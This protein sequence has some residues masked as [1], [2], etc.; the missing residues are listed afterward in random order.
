MDAVIEIGAVDDDLQ[1]MQGRVVLLK[2]ESEVR[3]ITLAGSV[4]E[5]LAAELRP[6]IVL[7]D[8]ALNNGT[9]P[10]DNVAALIRAGHK[11]IVNTVLPKDKLWIIE[12]TEAGASAYV[13][14]NSDMAALID[15]IR[16]VHNGETPTSP[17][18]ASALWGDDRP[19]APH[20]SPRQ[21]AIL[22]MVADGMPH[23][24]IARRLGIAA[25]TV[26]AHMDTVR[27]R[28]NKADLPITKTNYRDRVRERDLNHDRQAP[29]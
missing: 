4:A 13:T 7:L 17:E 27:E 20:L 9:L 5:Y 28:Y 24:A 15:A 16:A 19:S 6:Q 11:V 25:S 21:E 29:L 14:K 26:A 23:K 10:V 8:L 1:S 2:A 22:R 3:L 12:T 18:H